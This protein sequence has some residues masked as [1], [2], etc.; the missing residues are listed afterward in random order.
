MSVLFT[1]RP[2]AP[3]GF[4]R[5][6]SGRTYRPRVAYVVTAIAT[7]NGT[8]SAMPFY[9]Q[10]AITVNEISA[11]VEVAAAASVVRLGIYADD[12]TRRPGARLLDAGTVATTTAG[13]KTITIAQALAPGWH[14]FAAAPQGAAVT[15]WTAEGGHD[16]PEIERVGAAWS[17]TYPCGFEQTGVAG[18]LPASFSSTPTPVQNPV[19]VAF[20]VA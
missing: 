18:A 19:L 6:A 14:W 8:L 13:T 16:V 5:L 2:E 12:G 17:T 4:P 20:K 1:S 3:D 11:H 9:V 15:F 10:N 7:A